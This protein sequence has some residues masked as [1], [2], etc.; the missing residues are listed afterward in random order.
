MKYIK[1]ILL[2]SQS[3]QNARSTKVGKIEGNIK[4]HSFIYTK[5]KQK[6]VSFRQEICVTDVG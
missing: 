5:F 2:K 3:L 4:H 6:Y 1:S